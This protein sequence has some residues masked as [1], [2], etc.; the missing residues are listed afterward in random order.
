MRLDDERADGQSDG[1]P[2]PEIGPLLIV[3]GL[4]TTAGVVAAE[5][6]WPWTAPALHEGVKLMGIFVLSVR[7]RPR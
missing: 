4:L 3:A 1:S 5:I 6:L 7:R 2:S